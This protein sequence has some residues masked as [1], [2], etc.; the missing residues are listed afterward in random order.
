[1]DDVAVVGL[2]HAKIDV[3]RGIRGAL[4]TTADGIALLWVG[5]TAAEARDL[6]ALGSALN[7]IAYRIGT[8]TDAGVPCTT[9]VEGP[10]GC[11]AVVRSSPN[12]LLSMVGDT[13][14]AVM[15]IG[16][17]LEALARHVGP[18]LEAN[19]GGHLLAG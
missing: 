5:L 16:N 11:F 7:G 2:L 6:A 8:R 19:V 12:T 13:K 15:E 17:E 1:M 14:G 9:V 18:T 4:A 10:S 3:L